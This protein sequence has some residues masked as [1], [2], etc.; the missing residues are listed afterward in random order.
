MTE[1]GDRILRNS[2]KGLRKVAMRTIHQS[3]YVELSVM[4]R[5]ICHVYRVEYAEE[6][7]EESK[8]QRNH[9]PQNPTTWPRLSIP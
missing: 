7:R 2:N 8:F 9:I 4:E 1:Y 6:V 5:G 3:L